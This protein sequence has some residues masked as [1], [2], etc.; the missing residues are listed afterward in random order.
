MSNVNPSRLGLSNGTG[1]DD[2][3]FLKTFS[4]ETLAAFEEK[5]VFMPLMNV[6]TITSGKSAQFPVMGVNTAT[7][8]T[9]GTE[10][11]GNTI[12]LA[13]RVINI[14]GQLIAHVYIAS[15]DEAKNHYDVRSQFTTENANA[16][17]NHLD[18]LSARVLIN[19]ARAAS[20]ITGR[21][22]GTT[23]LGGATAATSSATLRTMAFNAAQVLDEKDVPEDNRYMVLKPAQYY[24]LAQ[25]TTVLNKD[26]G[27]QGSYSDGKVIK[28][29]D[30]TIVKS[31]H[32]PTTNLTDGVQSV[33][34]GDF[35]NSVGVVF[36]KSA[37]GVVKLID[38]QSEGEWQMSKQATLL[39]SKIACGLGS[40][41]AE[42][43]VELSKG[44]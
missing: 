41:R 31:N 15:I 18:R 25:D 33:Y 39:L 3:L 24:L 40:L 19:T 14:D 34:N 38:L 44:T 10:L 4:G 6:R 28:V 26:W 36:H 2:A 27:G 42:A 29:A 32:L 8:H 21:P 1:A 16:L 5:N 35:T 12:P 43:A 17:S 7:Y 9:P 11:T 23:L 13:E 30:L 20:V 22:G 37:A